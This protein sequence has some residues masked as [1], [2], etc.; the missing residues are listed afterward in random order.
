M[1]KRNMRATPYNL[2]TP[3][4]FFSPFFLMDT[5]DTHGLISTSIVKGWIPTVY[6]FLL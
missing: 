5:N 2:R 4:R 6:P 1:W 3:S